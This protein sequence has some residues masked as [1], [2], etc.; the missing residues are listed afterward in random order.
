MPFPAKVIVGCPIRDF[1]PI[2]PNMYIPR[3]EWFFTSDMSELALAR[4]LI[5][6]S[7]TLPSQKVSDTVMV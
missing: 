2:K 7:K 6:Y 5:K 3:R 4:A 1:L